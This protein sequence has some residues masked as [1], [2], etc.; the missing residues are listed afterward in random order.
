ML[1]MSRVSNNELSVNSNPCEPRLSVLSLSQFFLLLAVYDVIG[2]DIP[3]IVISGTEAPPLLF[4][5][6]DS[7]TEEGLRGFKV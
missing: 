1:N 3:Y 5:R 6:G 2:G 4:I 7:Q